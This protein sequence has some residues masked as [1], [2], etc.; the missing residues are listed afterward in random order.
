MRRI[1]RAHSARCL[2]QRSGGRAR[3]FHCT[4]AERLD[5]D[6]RA[7]VHPGGAPARKRAHHGLERGGEARSSTPGVF[8]IRT[9][10]GRTR[11]RVGRDGIGRVLALPPV[12]RAER[13]R[14]RARVE[15]HPSGAA[16]KRS[17][18]AT[19]LDYLRRDDVL[20]VLDVD[21]PGHRASELITLIDKLVQRGV[22]FRAHNLLADTTTPA[23]PTFLRIQAAFAEMERKVIR[24][25]IQEGIGSASRPANPDRPRIPPSRSWRAPPSFRRPPGLRVALLQEF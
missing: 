23:G 19:C 6:P 7:H 18:L 17:Q 5:D 22:G 8:R 4:R 11:S 3:S 21:C 10:R 20:V 9:M 12:R 15:G 1:R 25:C 16:P 13:R 24:Q 2:R 14:L